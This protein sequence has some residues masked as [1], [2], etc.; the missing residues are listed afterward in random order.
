MTSIGTSDFEEFRRKRDAW[1]EWLSGKDR[2]SIKNQIEQMIWDAAAFRA[3]NE[4]RRLAPP[5]DEGGPQL[6]GMTHDLINRGF[7][8]SQANAIRR[9]M[10]KSTAGG[11][12]G[13]YSLH[14]LLG[15]MEKNAHVMTREHI[16][17]AEGLAYDY[18]PVR[19]AYWEY[20]RQQTRA[21]K[22]AYGIPAHLS[23]DRLE[24]RHE[25][26][27]RLSG[28]V[29]DQ[30]SPDDS[31]RPDCFTRLKDKLDVCGEVR[32]YVNKFIAHAATP[33]SR[34]TV[35]ADDLAITLKHLWDA[36]EAVCRVANLLSIY[37]LGGSSFG[38]LAIP[39][40][41]QFAYIDRPLV[42]SGNISRLHD[43]W[44]EYDKET[45]EW[46]NWGLDE[47]EAEVATAPA[48]GRVED[49]S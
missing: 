28:V 25:V 1:I 18:E 43:V 11:A 39:Q 27:D 47:F 8:I 6:N 44:K 17:A 20:C 48:Q 24:R 23:W 14:G 36:H 45:H 7:F 19:T 29:K 9:L 21:G 4:A 40:F 32:T 10:E 5:S 26:I 41:D 22:G 38:G 46:G 31:V 3:I 49:A 42:A 33:G 13:V 15:D 30:R 16:F 34:A 37:V 12:R 2:H 35:N